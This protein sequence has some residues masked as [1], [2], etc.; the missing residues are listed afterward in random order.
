MIHPSASSLIS[1]PAA[2]LQPRVAAPKL[3]SRGAAIGTA[4]VPTSRGAAPPPTPI[5]N[6]ASQ[7]DLKCSDVILKS[8]PDFLENVQVD[9]YNLL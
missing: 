5:P 7:P 6:G 1:L 8:D 3:S 9:H 4:L 2:D